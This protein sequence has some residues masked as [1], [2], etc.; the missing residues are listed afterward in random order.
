MKQVG[1]ISIIDLA[2]EIGTYKRRYLVAS[3]PTMPFKCELAVDEIK[4]NPFRAPFIFMRCAIGTFYIYY[5]DS[6]SVSEHNGFRVY[7]IRCELT[8]GNY[9]KPGVFHLRCA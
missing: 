2:D 3:D 9:V 7:D 4:V 8:G 1:E 5:I 6:I